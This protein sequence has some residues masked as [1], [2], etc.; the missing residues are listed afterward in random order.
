MLNGKRMYVQHRDERKIFTIEM[1]LG[2]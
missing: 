2:F 1:K